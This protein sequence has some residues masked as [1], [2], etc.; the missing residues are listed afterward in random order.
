MLSNTGLLGPIAVG[1][2]QAVIDIDAI[3]TDTERTQSAAL[4]GEILLLC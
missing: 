4:G 3:I 2:G 1:A